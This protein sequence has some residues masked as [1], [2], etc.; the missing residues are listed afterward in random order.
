MSLLKSEIITSDINSFASE[1]I[2][3][4]RFRVSSIARLVSFFVVNTDV[5][6]NTLEALFASAPRKTTVLKKVTIYYL[7][8]LLKGF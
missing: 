4:I 1:I 2:A 6:G 7:S 3:G 5:L 8:D